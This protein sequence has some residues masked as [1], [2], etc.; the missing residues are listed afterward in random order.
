MVWP[1]PRPTR[2]QIVIGMSMMLAGFLLAFV[3]GPVTAHCMFP[4]VNAASGAE[5]KVHAAEIAHVGQITLMSA[6]AGFG[7]QR[8]G[9]FYSYCV[10]AAWFIGPAEAAAKASAA[11]VPADKAPATALPPTEKPSPAPKMADKRAA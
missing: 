7:L 4:N 10:L 3:V 11:K 9:L 8:V 2:I 6:V 5:I 1:I